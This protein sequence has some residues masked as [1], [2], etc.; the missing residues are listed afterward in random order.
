[1]SNI[2]RAV[3]VI[4]DQLPKPVAEHEFSVDYRNGLA[5]VRDVAGRAAEALADEGLLMPD[6]PPVCALTQET[7]P[8]WAQNYLD[9]WEWLPD[10]QFYGGS[11]TF[12]LNVKDGAING[13][14]EFGQEEWSDMKPAQ[15]REITAILRA[16]ADHAEKDIAE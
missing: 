5:I 6:L 10:V 2:E 15:L 8:E 13:G 11:S 3:A 9:E 14:F 1:M 4:A 12:Y 16:A 7:D